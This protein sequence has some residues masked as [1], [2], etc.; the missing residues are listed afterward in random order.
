MTA[1]MSM[2]IVR[3]ETSSVVSELSPTV[4]ERADAKI[5]GEMNGWIGRFIFVTL[6]LFYFSPYTI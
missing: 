6:A 4:V 5:E 3:G 1:M 2:E